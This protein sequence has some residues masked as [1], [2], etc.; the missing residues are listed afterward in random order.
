L[1][2]IGIFN[3]P[4]EGKIARV[5][6]IGSTNVLCGLYL[7]ESDG[8][9]VFVY[10]ES[11]GHVK[12]LR[13]LRLPLSSALIKII[14]DQ[15]TC[16]GLQSSSERRRHVRVAAAAAAGRLRVRISAAAPA[17]RGPGG[18]GL[19]TGP[20]DVVHLGRDVPQRGADVIDLIRHFC[21]WPY[22]I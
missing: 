16:K 6:Q 10:E 5:Q 14:P 13:T 11:T 9:D 18:G 21:W 12:R 15:V 17:A 3:N 4:W 22:W 1:N 7:G 20:A 8:A 19:G 2:A